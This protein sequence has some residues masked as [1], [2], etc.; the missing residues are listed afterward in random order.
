MQKIAE[1]NPSH[2]FLTLVVD[3]NSKDG[4]QEVVKKFQEKNKDVFLLTGPKKGL[5]HDLIRGY[6]Y[7]ADKLKADVVIPNDADFQWDPTH[8]PEM[9]KKIEDGY[10]VVVASRHTKGGCL[11]A[12]S[13]IK[14]NFHALLL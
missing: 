2:K 3:A 13:L 8:I 6:R 11:L 5:G 12:L 9:I 14:S 7:A 10:D 1:K 4:T